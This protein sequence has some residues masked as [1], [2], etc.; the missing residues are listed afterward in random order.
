MALYQPGKSSNITFLLSSLFTIVL[1]TITITGH[2]VI[3]TDLWFYFTEGSG[4]EAISAS[5]G[6]PEAL[7]WLSVAAAF[8]MDIWIVMNMRKGHQKAK[9]R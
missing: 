4:M 7:L 3:I 5:T 8:M 6:L 2:L 9:R 1:L